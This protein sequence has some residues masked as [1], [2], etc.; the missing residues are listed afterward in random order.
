MKEGKER[1]MEAVYVTVTEAEAMKTDL[2]GRPAP[3]KSAFISANMHITGDVTSDGSLELE[4]HVI[5]NIDVLG[6]L[7]ISGS[8]KGDSQAEE[9]F[10]DNAK[11][12]GEVRSRGR[13]RIGQSTVIIGNIFAGSAMIA[14]AVKGDIDVHGPVI[15]DNTAVIMGNIKSKSV[16][17]NNGAVIEGMCTQAYADISPTSFFAE[18]KKGGV[19]SK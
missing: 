6:R 8:L 9:I 13:A 11:I 12:D 3:D 18:F 14:G 5:G 7:S 15:L 10:T 4:G 1:Y 2:P 19:A 17:I 16:Q